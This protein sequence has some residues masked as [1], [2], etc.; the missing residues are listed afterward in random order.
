MLSR[1]VIYFVGNKV[2]YRC[3]VAEHSENF[4]DILS[5]NSVGITVG[6]LLPEAILMKNPMIDYSTMLL[7]YTQRALTDQNDAPRA[8][9]GI[10]RRFTN[11][12]KCRFL[13]GL[14]T[15]LFDQFILF[16]ANK[17]ILHRRSSFPSYSWIGWR[18]G[19]DVHDDPGGLGSDVNNWLRKKTW[20]IW[21]KRNPSGLTNLVWDPSANDSFPSQD[22]TYLGY[23]DRSRFSDGRQTSKQ[24]D[25]R[26]TMPTEEVSFSRVT[27]VYPLLQFWTISVFYNITNI[28]VFEATGYLTDL[29]N[30]QC[31]FALLDGFEETTFFESKGPFEVILLSESCI[32]GL[33]R[34]SVKFDSHSKRR[35]SNASDQTYYNVLLLEWRGGI[36]ERRGFGHIFQD[37][38]DNS[39]APGPVWKEIFLA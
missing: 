12:M 28:D 3:R 36:A 4:A 18:G 21:Y 35:Y 8:M 22:M 13:E 27:P 34:Y 26:R 23:R 25:T 15:A 29:D 10:I 30:V 9:A 1:R 24:L 17:N 14:P 2:F 7:Y 38:V 5:N 11:V 19:I 20:I 33:N 31:G 37:A 6:S 39:L 32:L 16:Y